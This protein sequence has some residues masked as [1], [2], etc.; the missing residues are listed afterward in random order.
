MPW[1]DGQI[2]YRLDDEP[3]RRIDRP[4]AVIGQTEGADVRIVDRNVSSRHT[5]LHLDRRGL[6][7]L[8]LA[9]RQGMLI[10]GVST[11][12]GWLRPGQVLGIA[13][14]RI[15]IVDLVVDGAPLPRSLATPTRLPTESTSAPLVRISIQ[16][17]KDAT[18]PWTLNS[19][20]IVLGR[21]P[22]CGIIL[23]GATVARVHLVIFRTPGAAFA[24]NLVGW[25]TWVRD[26]PLRDVGILADG[27]ILATGS[28][29]YQVRIQPSSRGPEAASR[30]LAVR[31]AET[32][33]LPALAAE[34]AWPSEIIPT[35]PPG[36]VPAEAQGAI[37][38]WMM[39]AVQALQTEMLRRQDVL[40]HELTQAVHSLHQHQAEALAAHQ[41]RVEAIHQELATL[42]EEI[43]QRFQ[44]PVPSAQV[45]APPKAPPLRITPGTPATD[46]ETATA[47]L[48]DRVQSLD[49][50]TRASW[51]DLLGRFTPPSG[52]K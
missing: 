33:A 29:R 44:T 34:P 3:P 25:G 30:S 21:S 52:R 47:W 45:P 51:R 36:L 15:E 13:G 49:T 35:P 38:A 18:T 39:G 1:V 10:D 12:A 48:L 14:R 4:F 22:A 16:P 20:L 40:Q 5:Y 32:S 23:E 43:R 9:T 46:P 50:E 28:S 41:S 24:V 6:F 2:V 17:E 26:R 11:P 37:L 42:R 31:P 8:D 7:A 19:E 27:D